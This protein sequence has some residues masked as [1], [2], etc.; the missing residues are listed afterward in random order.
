MMMNPL[1]KQNKLYFDRESIINYTY[2]SCFDR[3]K[4][5]KIEIFL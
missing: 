2:D 3:E 5:L 1:N 4:F